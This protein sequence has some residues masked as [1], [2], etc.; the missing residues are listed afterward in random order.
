[1]AS[2]LAVWC[3]SISKYCRLCSLGARRASSVWCRSKA[4]CPM[5]Q[6]EDPPTNLSNHGR[7]GRASSPLVKYLEM[8]V[9]LSRSASD[10]P[11]FGVPMTLLSGGRPSSFG[12]QKSSFRKA[13]NFCAHENK[14][15]H[16]RKYIFA[17]AEINFLIY[18]NKFSY[19]RKFSSFR[20]EVFRPSE[21]GVFPS[22]ERPFFSSKEKTFSCLGKLIFLRSKNPLR[23]K[24]KSLAFEGKRSAVRRAIFFR[25]YG[26]K[27]SYVRKFWPFAERPFCPR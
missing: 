24:E 27:F 3:I 25:T 21:G 4:T 14:F 8:G 6:K 15:P 17:Y 9:F 22:E 18:G 20:T 5:G 1:M 7:K 16:M 11:S 26:N 2:R 19:I 10:L 23:T 12:W 13:K